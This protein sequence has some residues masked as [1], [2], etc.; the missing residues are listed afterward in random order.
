MRTGGSTGL[1]EDVT[2]DSGGRGKRMAGGAMS[3][4]E[5]KEQLAAKEQ[6]LKEL[7]VRR[8]RVSAELKEVEGEIAALAGRKAR[9]VR[10]LPTEHLEE[11][12]QGQR[13]TAL[14]TI[15]GVDEDLIG[16]AHAV[17]HDPGRRLQPPGLGSWMRFHTFLVIFSAP[18]GSGP[19]RRTAVSPRS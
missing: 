3:I 15:V 10:V 9:R 2:M 16:P 7:R 4:S 13:A 6:E 19:C 5:L 8:E 11:A 1:P 12:F 17:V 18:S 14:V